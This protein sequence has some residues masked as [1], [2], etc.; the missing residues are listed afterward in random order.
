MSVGKRRDAFIAKAKEV[1]HD[2]QYDYSEFIYVNNSTAGIIYCETHDE[3]FIQRPDNHLKGYKK[4]EQCLSPDG[5]SR[6]TSAISAI[7]K[8]KE[9]H[10]DLYDYSKFGK[11]QNSKSQIIVICNTCGEEF[12]TTIDGHLYHGTGCKCRA[13]L[14]QSQSNYKKKHI[15][16][17]NLITEFPEIAEEFSYKNDRDVSSF[18]PF[19]HEKVWWLC[20]KNHEYEMVISNRTKSKQNCPVCA[21]RKLH[22]DNDL[23]NNPD[24]VLQWDY[25][26]NLL[27]PKDYMK[28]SGDTAWF[29]CDCKNDDVELKHSFQMR[30]CNFHTGERCPYR[31]GKKCDFAASIAMRTPEIID[32]WDFDKNDEDPTEINYGSGKYYW[33]KCPDCETEWKSTPNV[34]KLGIIS[35]PQCRLSGYS[36]AAIKWLETLPGNIQHAK[37]GGEFK[38]PGTNYRADGYCAETNT[39]YEFHG[40]FWHG[41]P[42]VYDPN[43]INPVVKKTYGELFE[44]TKQK[45]RTIRELGYNLVVMWE[46]DFVM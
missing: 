29:I 19:S 25:E 42:A 37:N 33:L 17:C 8:C 7:A 31:A 27:T 12:T 24:A 23:S 18:S 35:C 6:K 40:T 5:I 2:K 34:I 26:R 32:Y 3:K 36:T 44:R 1:H 41:D 11:P 28:G 39:I 16:I 45:E 14:A 38:I 21:S 46:K 13:K 20:P 15:N 22:V 9:K 4:C 43:E 10:G 30:I